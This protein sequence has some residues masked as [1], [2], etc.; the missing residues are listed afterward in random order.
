MEHEHARRST[1][2][3]EIPW[4]VIE[5]AGNPTIRLDTRMLDTIVASENE[6]TLAVDDLRVS[7][8]DEAGAEDAKEIV[9]KLQPYTRRAPITREDVYDDAKTR[10]RVLSEQK[11]GRNDGKLPDTGEPGLM[12]GEDPVF[13]RGEYLCVGEI[14][15]FTMSEVQA[16]ALAGALLPIPNRG[17]LQ[18]AIARLVAPVAR[19]KVEKDRALLAK[20]I[21]AYE[22]RRR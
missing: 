3:V 7:M 9:S 13:A 14:F 5:A 10:L 18:A 11:H 16:Y 12:F 4:L 1:I 8:V 17:V 2:G 6:L 15:H 20:R 22:A 19:R 21:K